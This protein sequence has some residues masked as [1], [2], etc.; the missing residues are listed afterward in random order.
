[1]SVETKSA[2]PG[3]TDVPNGGS[4]AYPPPNNYADFPAAPAAPSNYPAYPPAPASYPTQ[5]SY[6][7]YPPYPPQPGYPPGAYASTTVVVPGTV[8]P[9]APVP[10]PAYLQRKARSYIISGIVIAASGGVMVGLY[11]GATYRWAAPLLPLRRP[12][13]PLAPRSDRYNFYWWIGI[14]LIVLGL[15]FI[16]YG[17]MMMRKIKQ[18]AANPP[19]MPAPVPTGQGYGSPSGA[20]DPNAV[21][22]SGGYPPPQPQGGY[23]PPQGGQAF[24]EA[25]PPYSAPPRT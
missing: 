15:A 18:A 14:I 6:S 10:A 20:Y 17:I 22:P 16:G 19:P 1:M 13:H 25:P 5:Q 8:Q 9:A 12:A 7:S 23:P 24:P 3:A 4:S 11:Y 21:Y 2:P